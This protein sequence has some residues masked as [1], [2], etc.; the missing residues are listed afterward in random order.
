M[1]LSIPSNHRFQVSG[2]N[3]QI[4][5]FKLTSV[6]GIGKLRDRWGSYQ[7][8]N[9]AIHSRPIQVYIAARPEYQ[10]EKTN[11]VAPASR[12]LFTAIHA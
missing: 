11:F 3:F 7:H 10:N 12:R 5:N 6:F 4:S 8:L 1:S 2:L 9:A